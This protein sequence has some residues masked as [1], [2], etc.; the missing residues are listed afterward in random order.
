MF[1]RKLGSGFK[2]FLYSPRKLGK[3]S[4]LTNIFQMGWF[5][6]QPVKMLESSNEKQAIYKM[7]GIR[8]VAT[9][10][11]NQWSSE[12]ATP[13]ILCETSGIRKIL[14]TLYRNS[15]KQIAKIPINQRV[16]QECH[17]GFDG[18]PAIQKVWFRCFSFFK[19]CNLQL[20]CE[21]ST[22]FFGPS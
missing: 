1:L 14:P 17:K 11:K 20:P 3:M 15:H 19:G 4:N 21:F 16:F 12:H 10:K 9:T 22:V 18:T 5:N 7:D 13:R 8:H 6:H 2:D